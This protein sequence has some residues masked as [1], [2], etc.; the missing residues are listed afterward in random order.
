MSEIDYANAL[1]PVRDDLVAAHRRA[2]ER[3]ARPGTWWSG[4]ERV[5]IAAEVRSAAEC[6]L[7]R[8]R[9]AALSPA[10]VAGE[11]ASRGALP[12]VAVEVIHRVT[13]DPAR[14]SKAWFEKCQAGGLGDAHY[15]ET[16]GVIA[17]VVSIDDFCRGLGM[18]PHPLPDPIPGE[19]SRRRPPGALP[20]DAWV[21]MIR[22]SRAT[23]AEADLYEGRRATGNVLR[24][25]SLVPDEVRGL[26]DLSAAH[27]LS[28]TKMLD[29]R[30]GT[31]A[32][33]RLQVELLAGR[34]SA[35][36]ECFY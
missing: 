17:T 1:V 36:N 20:E 30:R 4:A 31:P 11:H 25:L 26:M 34:V 27:Y 3:L 10:G 35:L 13:T 18:A 15:V 16:I 33:D 5:A 9:K 29:L 6:A 2:W 28:P 8:E 23:G 19:P 32:L 24:A 12:E 7:C 22:E 14:L 21:P